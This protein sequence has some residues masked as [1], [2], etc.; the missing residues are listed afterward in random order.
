MKKAK[1]T[2]TLILAIMILSLSGFA[3]ADINKTMPDQASLGDVLSVIIDVNNTD[4]NNV[5]VED[6]LPDNLE[7]LP[8]SLQVDGVNTVPATYNNTLAVDVNSGTHQI[9]FDVQA[10][11]VEA[12][13]TTFRS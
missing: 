13:E 4:V 10:V 1:K 12:Q 3:R 7:L 11:E 5:I 6:I 2:I 8:A 9:T